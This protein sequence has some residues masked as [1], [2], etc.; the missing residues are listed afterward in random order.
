MVVLLGAVSFAIGRA[1]LALV[2]RRMR[3]TGELATA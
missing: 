3:V 1:V 2:L